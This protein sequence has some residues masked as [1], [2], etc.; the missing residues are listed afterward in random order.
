MF[1]R[2]DSTVLVIHQLLFIAVGTKARRSK[3]FERSGPSNV[4]TGELLVAAI[5]PIEASA[6]TST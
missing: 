5:E 2:K 4:I 6:H 3:D 1:V